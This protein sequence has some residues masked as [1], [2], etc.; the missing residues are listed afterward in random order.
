MTFS[1]VQKIVNVSI[2]ANL[3]DDLRFALYRYQ[4]LL[5]KYQY[6]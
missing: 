6:F 3:C 4:V 1:I 5:D 2:Y